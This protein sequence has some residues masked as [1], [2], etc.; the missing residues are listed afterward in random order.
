MARLEDCSQGK[1]VKVT[2]ID[3]ERKLKMDLRTRELFESIIGE[4]GTIIE[5]DEKSRL[6]R[7]KLDSGAQS[8]F[9]PEELE[10]IQTL[11]L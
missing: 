1:R 3:L 9:L 7:F 2:N 4:P 8:W 10:M 5:I 11:T 6:V